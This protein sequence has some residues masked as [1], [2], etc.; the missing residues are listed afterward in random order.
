MRY[1]RNEKGVALVMA[2]VFAMVGLAIVSA[3]MF[4]ITQGTMMSGYN[5]QFRSADEAGLGAAPVA[6]EYITG[7]GT[8]PAAIDLQFNAGDPANP[9]Q[10]CLNQKLTL[11]RGSWGT[12]ATGWTLCGGY[13]ILDLDVAANADLIYR[14]PGDNNRQ[15]RVYTK[16]IDT[17]KGNTEGGGRDQMGGQ[18]VTYSSGEI[19]P[20][21]LPSIYRVEIQAEDRDDPRER[22]KY[23]LLYAN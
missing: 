21:S 19:T 5:R 14:L 11:S 1:L 2:L 18:A 10:P 13:D 15:Y 12:S 20:P 7:N 23:T 6:I 22:S 4:M 16:I 3:M 17:V 8:P 9:Q